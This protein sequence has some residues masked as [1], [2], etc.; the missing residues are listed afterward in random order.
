M[1]QFSSN[2]LEIQARYIQLAFLKQRFHTHILTLFG[3]L[4]F[5]LRDK[6][7]AQ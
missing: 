3:E 5:E 2:L 6:C 7:L 1:K 4:F